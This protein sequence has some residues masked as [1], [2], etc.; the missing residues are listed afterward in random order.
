MLKAFLPRQRRTSVTWRRVHLRTF[1][2]L[3][4]GERFG[5]LTLPAVMEQSDISGQL[6]AGM[7][8]LPPLCLRGA[9]LLP[10]VPHV[11]AEA[12]SSLCF[13]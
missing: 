1:A 7:P 6:G 13:Q 8:L 10:Q 4:K 5:V 3:L 11:T 2:S 12:L 9:F